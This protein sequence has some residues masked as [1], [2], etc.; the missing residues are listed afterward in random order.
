[1]A[2]ERLN[3]P[4]DRLRVRN[5]VV[6]LDDDAAKSVSYA[7]LVGGRELGVRVG[8]KTKTKDPKDYRIVGK[9]VARF[10]I[11]PKV[12]G[13]YRYVGDLRV[14]GM[15]HGRVVRPPEAGAKIVHVDLDARLPG[16]VKVVRR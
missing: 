12:R 11:P 2:A 9:P 5:G 15:L 13:D 8:E 14:D 10:D 3:A 1:L 6:Y 7:E 4:A 16:L